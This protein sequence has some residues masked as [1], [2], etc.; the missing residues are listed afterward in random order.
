MMTNKF[1]VSTIYV[2][3]AAAVLF[4]TDN[5]EGASLIVLFGIL[6]R[7]TSMGDD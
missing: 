3:A 7:L 1:V 2:A 6:M 5:V 4:F